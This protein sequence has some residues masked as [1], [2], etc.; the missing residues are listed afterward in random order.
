MSKTE[1]KAVAETAEKSAAD[2]LIEMQLKA[3]KEKALNPMAIDSIEEVKG[4]KTSE[5]V[6]IATR[7]VFANGSVLEA[8]A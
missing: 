7:I 5:G 1:T 6:N 2:L 4:E 3:E 8:L